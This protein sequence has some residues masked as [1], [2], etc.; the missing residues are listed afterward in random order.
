MEGGNVTELGCGHSWSLEE[1]T[2]PH[3]LGVKSEG[4]SENRTLTLG[5]GGEIEDKRRKRRRHL[6]PRRQSAQMA[7][8]G[9]FYKVRKGLHVYKYLLNECLTGK[10]ELRYGCISFKTG[11]GSNKA[12]KVKRAIN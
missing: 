3:L 12:N 1:G 4:F 5:F 6:K 8:A 7:V 11:S 9:Q 10:A 2:Q